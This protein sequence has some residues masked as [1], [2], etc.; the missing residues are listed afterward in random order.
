MSHKKKKNKK[1][2]NVFYRVFKAQFVHEIR[3]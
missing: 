3:N 1:K 2:I